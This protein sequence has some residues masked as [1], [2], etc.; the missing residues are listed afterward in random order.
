MPYLVFRSPYRPSPILSSAAVSNTRAIAADF[1][2]NP[3]V[4]DLTG[5]FRLYKTSVLKEVSVRSTSVVSVSKDRN[6]K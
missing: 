5:S 4:S 2:L 3:G 6:S 1:L